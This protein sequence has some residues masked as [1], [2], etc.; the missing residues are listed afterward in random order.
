M[1]RYGGRVTFCVTVSVELRGA[2]V[3]QLPMKVKNQANEMKVHD[4]PI[5]FND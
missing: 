4:I 2:V 3:I 1:H 5:R